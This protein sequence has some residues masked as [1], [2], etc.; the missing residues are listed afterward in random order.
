MLVFSQWPEVLE[1][2]AHGLGAHGVTY[3]A[4][5]A[6]RA[7]ALALRRFQ[8]P[9]E[10]LPEDAEEAEGRNLRAGEGACTPAGWMID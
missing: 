6:G 7:L 9:L 10:D 1:L 3:A 8:R 2:L 4:G 5:K